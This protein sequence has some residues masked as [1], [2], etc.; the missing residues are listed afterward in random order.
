MATYIMLINYSDQGIRN[1]KDSPKR[2]DAAKKMLKSM[3]GEIKEFYLTMGSY[4]LAIVAEA[5]SDDVIA[6]FALASGSLG[7]IRTTT[8]KAFPEAEYRKIIAA[9]P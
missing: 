9:L 6:K 1:V 4:D 8:L 5:P 7:N 2:L 3:G